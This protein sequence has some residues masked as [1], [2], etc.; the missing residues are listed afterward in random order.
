M[1][2]DGFADVIVG[3]PL[4]NGGFSSEGGSFIFH[5]NSDGRLVGVQQRRGD[6]AGTAV[7]PWGAAYDT[8]AF[9]VAVTATHPAGRGVVKL[10][11]EACEPGVA[12]D[13]ASCTIETSASRKS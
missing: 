4:Y 11:V 13:D 12:F 6:G 2:A 5:G 8:A 10:E 3:A 7:Q 9:E 1:N